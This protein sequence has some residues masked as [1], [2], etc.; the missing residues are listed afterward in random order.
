MSN[1]FL[2]QVLVGEYYCSTLMGDPELASQLQEDADYLDPMPE[3]DGE[4]EVENDD[5]SS[6]V[7][8]LTLDSDEEVEEANAPAQE[9]MY[10][11]DETQYLADTFGDYT[12]CDKDC[13]SLFKQDKLSADIVRVF[14]NAEKGK[15]QVIAHGVGIRFEGR[16]R[17]RCRE[18]GE[19]SC[20][21][22]CSRG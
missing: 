10:T 11:V 7:G 18:A 22:W 8:P 9:L 6:V 15:T 2:R 21:K 3:V 5:D 17:S 16:H 13:L 1:W 19:V 20:K 14:S 12:C 4:E